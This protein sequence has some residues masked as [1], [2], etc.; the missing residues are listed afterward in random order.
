MSK[1]KKILVAGGSH[2]EL[3]VIESAKKL[4]FYV[5]T[6]GNDEDSIGHKYADKYIKGDYSDKDFIFNLA[7]QEKVEG[8]VSGA[9]DF[10][11]LSVSYACE[12]LGLKGHDSYETAKRIHIKNEFR[13]TLSKL[14]IKTPLSLKCNS[15][16]ECESIL[17]NFNYPVVVK[18]V[19]LTGGKGVKFCSN[20]NEVKT[21]VEFALAITRE[22]HVVIEQVIKGSNHGFSSFIKDQKV[23]WYLID[24]EQ[25]GL[26]KYLVLGASSPSDIPQSAEFTLIN[27]IE[28]LAREC[29]FTD[30]LFHVQFI[31]DETG[32]PVMID[33]CRRM[34][35]DLY[36]LLSKY[37]TGVDVPS[38]ILN[39]EIGNN[40]SIAFSTEHNFVARE[41]IMGKSKGKIKDVYIDDYLKS[42]IIY[43]Y[44]RDFK[45]D[46]IEDPMKYKAGILIMK[47]ESYE[48][49]KRCL[50]NFESL[51][52]IEME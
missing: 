16:Y 45:K 49:M 11:Y 12:K 15:V 34:P 44:F 48:D 41:C 31:L 14:N 39:Y 26:N 30:G 2:S 38:L 7:K 51:A 33:P 3:P 52:R 46:T 4:G 47:F 1:I 17:K 28:K 10:S 20:V 24:N 43:S 37:V 23:I 13:H 21:A 5:I 9:N 27:D 18:P 40:D 6:T 22:K 19:D 29:N 36:I 8:I 42:K 50:L 32:Y 35:G 25:Y